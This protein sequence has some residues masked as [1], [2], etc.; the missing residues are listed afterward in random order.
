MR[1]YFNHWKESN[2]F[3]KVALNAKIKSLIIK[4]YKNK[5]TEV[6]TKLK[7]KGEKKKR[8][9]KKMISEA[10]ESNNETM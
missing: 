9:K 2:K 3:H 10:I 4:C 1:S 7:A 5:L 6:M 8:R